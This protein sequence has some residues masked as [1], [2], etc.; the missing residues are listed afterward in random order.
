L[1]TPLLERRVLE[2]G[3]A[4]LILQGRPLHFLMGRVSE[5]GK[6]LSWIHSLAVR[7]SAQRREIL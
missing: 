5:K 7:R 6:L 3:K 2:R 4:S 1:P